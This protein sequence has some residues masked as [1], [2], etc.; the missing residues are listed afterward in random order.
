MAKQIV[1]ISVATCSYMCK[2]GCREHSY[3]VANIRDDGRFFSVHISDARKERLTALGIVRRDIVA[4]G[5][6]YVTNVYYPCGAAEVLSDRGHHLTAARHP[7]SCTLC[8]VR[9]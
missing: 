7:A 8:R 6:M 4:E 2:R 1:S 5:Y 3:F 9:H